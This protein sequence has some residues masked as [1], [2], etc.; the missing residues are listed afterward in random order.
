MLGRLVGNRL[1]QIHLIRRLAPKRHMST[2]R[3]VKLDISSQSRAERGGRFV[4]IEI[5]VFVLHA[6]PPPLYH[7]IVNPPAFTVH[8]DVNIMSLENAGKRLR[9][10]LGPLVRIEAL[11]GAISPQR[12]FQRLHT[13]RTLQ[14][15]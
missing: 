6:A 7:H 2:A 3:V 11:G 15:V 13:E 8:A 4:R 1:F 9:C 12:L 5:D 10:E 14:R